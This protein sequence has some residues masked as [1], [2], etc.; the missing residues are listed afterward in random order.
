MDNNQ[1]ENNKQME[2][3]SFVKSIATGAVGAAVAVGGMSDAFGRESAAQQPPPQQKKKLLMKVGCQS[4]GT[5][6]ENLEFKARHGVYNLDGGA[7]K[8]IKE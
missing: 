8:Y 7:P 3:R 6:K 5:T 4:G 1:P 2:R